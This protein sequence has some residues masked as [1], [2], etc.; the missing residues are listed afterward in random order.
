MESSKEYLEFAE[1]CDRLAKEA[2]TERHRRILRK[3]AEAWR[4]VAKE[5]AA[6]ILS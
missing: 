2:E 5:R 3:M 6:P 1:E 4:Q